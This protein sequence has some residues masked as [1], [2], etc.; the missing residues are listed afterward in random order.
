MVIQVPSICYTQAWVKKITI[1]WDIT[2][3]RPF[4]FNRRFGGTC[5]L[6]FEGRRISKQVIFGNQVER[7]AKLATSKWMRHVPPKR[8]LTY[9]GLHGVVYQKTELFITTAVGTSDPTQVKKKVKFSL[10]LINQAVCHNGIWGS[11]GIAP[12][13]LTSELVGGE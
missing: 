4:K 9:N 6:H 3:C 11:G 12:Q 10:C 8:R 5:R 13:I 2:S 1:F 7:K